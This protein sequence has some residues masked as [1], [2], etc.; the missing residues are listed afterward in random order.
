MCSSQHKVVATKLGEQLELVLLGKVDSCTAIQAC[1]DTDPD[2]GTDAK[3]SS[4][5]ASCSMPSL[6]PVAISLNDTRQHVNTSE[7]LKTSQKAL[8][9]GHN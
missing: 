2:N 6:V 5:L 1:L 4:I 3:L 8:L 7:T 9:A